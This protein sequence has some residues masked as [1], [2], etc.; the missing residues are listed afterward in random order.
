MR[1]SEEGVLSSPTPG[2]GFFLSG[3]SSHTACHTLSALSERSHAQLLPWNWW[4]LYKNK[5]IIVSSC[6]P[7]V[8]PL[9]CPNASEWET[10]RGSFPNYL[11]TTPHLPIPTLPF[12]KGITHTAMVLGKYA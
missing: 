10:A 5:K 1:L 8:A 4:R 9:A 7:T 2:T 6:S 12:K 3:C 11:A